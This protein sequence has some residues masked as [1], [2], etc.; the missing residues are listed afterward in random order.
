MAG[1]PEYGAL[2]WLV[3]SQSFLGGVLLRTEEQ[4]SLVK[5]VNRDKKGLVCS[6]ELKLVYRGLGSDAIL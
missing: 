2:W 5:G 1:T 3:Q 4:C 6:V